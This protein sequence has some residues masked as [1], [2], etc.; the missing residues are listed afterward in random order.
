MTSRLPSDFTDRLALARQ[1]VARGAAQPPTHLADQLG[2]AGKEARGLHQRIGALAAVLHPERPWRHRTDHAPSDEVR[3]YL[4]AA[5]LG[6]MGDVCCHLRKGGP[7]PALV[8]L[9]LHRV[10]CT[11]CAGIVRRPPPGE[12][13]RCDVCGARGVVTF[14]PFSVHLG[15]T[16]VTG[17]ACPACAETL[18][19]SLKERTA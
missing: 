14:H 11:R 19:I 2:A 18:G 16:I 5:A 13:D 9:P 12:D 8:L 17:D 15:P 3:T 7:Q 4:L 1:L 6:C 10:V